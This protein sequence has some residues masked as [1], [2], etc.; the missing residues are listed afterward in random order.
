LAVKWLYQL[1]RKSLTPPPP[2]LALL[3]MCKE[4]D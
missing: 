3:L 1:S 2:H 4:D